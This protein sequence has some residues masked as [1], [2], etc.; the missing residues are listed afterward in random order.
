MRRHIFGIAALSWAATSALGGP[1]SSPTMHSST[2]SSASPTASCID[3]QFVACYSTPDHAAVYDHRRHYDAEEPSALPRL[4]QPGKMKRAVRNADYGSSPSGTTSDD[5]S[6]ESTAAA[7]K[8]ASYSISPEATMTGQAS[9]VP[10][11][12]Q[13]PS[14]QG[15]NAIQD[16]EVQAMSAASNAR[17]GSS[18]VPVPT[19]AIGLVG[20]HTAKTT[21][22]PVPTSTGHPKREEDASTSTM[23]SMPGPPGLLKAPDA[24]G[25]QGPT[26]THLGRREEDART[27]VQ[28]HKSS[29]EHPGATAIAN[30]QD[31]DMPNM[32][33]PT[34]HQKRHSEHDEE[35]AASRSSSTAHSSGAVPG[36]LNVHPRALVP[37]V[38]NPAIYHKRHDD[39]RDDAMTSTMHDEGHLLLPTPPSHGVSSSMPSASH[40]A[41]AKRQAVLGVL[42]PSHHGQAPPSVSQVRAPEQPSF[43]PPASAPTGSGK[44]EEEA[45][46]PSP[47]PEGLPVKRHMGPLHSFVPQQSPTPGSVM[48]A[49]FASS[50][51]VSHSS[52][53]Q[54]S[55]KKADE[56]P[57][58]TD[59]GLPSHT[60]P[61]REVPVTVS[62]NFSTHTLPTHTLAPRGV[63]LPVSHNFSTHTLPTHTLAPRA[64]SLPVSH[65][66]STHTLPTHM[67]VPRQMHNADYS[68]G[69]GTAA[70][71][72]ADPTAAAAQKRAVKV[73]AHL[74]TTENRAPYVPP[75][76]KGSEGD[77]GKRGEE[78]LIWS[79]AR[80]EVEATKSA[81]ASATHE[82]LPAPTEKL[83]NYAGM[84]KN[85]ASG[86]ERVA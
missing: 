31:Y 51:S 70:Q 32:T 17:S 7:H 13:F 19:G 55:T 9:A 65:N 25:S 8:R 35:V 28:S 72:Q 40:G 12:L 3:S 48:M 60:L 58:S 22:A 43:S 74:P 63:A 36:I 69:N 4:H 44:S 37:H 10:V 59:Q 85:G 56:M 78:A 16:R 15:H 6:P 45:S 5:S 79:A 71:A 41:H 84:H 23:C 53:Q 42:I 39:P 38:P 30:V 47:T 66:F 54:H 57:V 49:D 64:V 24:H 81:S 2:V 11:R 83:E 82:S 50:S 77:A 33:R 20:A 86:R 29:T 62:H 61:P 46:A 68:N 27:S 21:E 73:A 1:M 80:R 75:G 14:H 52:G 18:E 34:P 76:A 26:T 67:A